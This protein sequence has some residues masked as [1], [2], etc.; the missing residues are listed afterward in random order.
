MGRKSLIPDFSSRAADYERLRPIDDNWLEVFEVVV[1]EAELRGARVLDVGCGTGKFARVLAERGLA[2]VWGIDSSAEMLDE[3]RERVPSSVGLKLGEAE[4]LPFKDA[5]FDAAVL[6]T[7]VHLIERP[8]A[9]A[10][11]HRVL[12]FGGRVAIVTFAPEHFTSYWQNEFFPSIA[13]I[14]LARH[15]SPKQL[16]EELQAA[17][18][19]APRF[20]RL[21]QTTELGREVALERIRGRAISTFDLLDEDEISAGTEKAE[22]ELPERVSYEVRYLLAFARG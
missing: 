12:A 14:D 21:L 1:R 7:V 2:R 9:F 16:T 18:F 8:L 20:V 22:R 17:G 5:Y 10:E 3:A 4:R 11:L 19:E 13:E 6:W 15:P